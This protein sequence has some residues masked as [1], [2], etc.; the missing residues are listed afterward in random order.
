M[1]KKIIFASDYRGIE[2]REKLIE[3]AAQRGIF[4]QDIGIPAGSKIDYIDISKYLAEEI[5]L[6][7]ESIG[8]MVCGSGQGVAI[9]LNRFTHIRACVCRTLEDAIQV[10]EKLNA[11]VLCLG[12]KQT[13]FLES[14]D[15]LENFI[16]TPFSG[17]KH[18]TCVQK[19]NTNP[20]HNGGKKINI[21]VRAIIIHNNHVLLTTVTDENP[22]FPP[23]IYFLP[24]GHVD[25]NE[26][27]LA[28]LNREIFEET[29]L[30]ID[31]ARFSGALECS[32]E[33]QGSLYHE[34]NIIYE[35][36]IKNLDIRKPPL[37][38]E[39]FQKFI[40]VP[41]EKLSQ[42]TVLP[43]KINN[44]ITDVVMNRKNNLYSEIIS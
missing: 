30:N 13:S 33:R 31:S 7:P 8:V 32:W 4:N 39:I 27:C 37:S 15:I 23:D 20:S 43:K 18:T 9:V 24:G 12:S 17:G 2:L 1:T 41:L 34:I 3:S 29:A 22:Y 26:S 36:T 14:L 5:R 38:M 19:L 44:V 40:W 21:I 28:A 11:N 16:K 42:I 25:Y 10:R 35:T 6:N